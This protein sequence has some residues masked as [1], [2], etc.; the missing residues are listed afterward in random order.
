MHLQI[1]WEHI[2][3]TTYYI[4]IHTTAKLWNHTA[5]SLFPHRHTSNTNSLPN[6]SFDRQ[7]VW[8]SRLRDAGRKEIFAEFNAEICVRAWSLDQVDAAAG[9]WTSWDWWS[10][11]KE[12]TVMRMRRRSR[13]RPYY[14]P[15]MDTQHDDVYWWVDVYSR[16]YSQRGLTQ[17][18]PVALKMWVSVWVFWK[19]LSMRTQSVFFL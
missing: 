13:R 16:Y 3:C 14:A 4:G 19:Y 6:V 18:Q 5:F 2:V 15:T 7:Q 10:G 12:G 9:L 11:E 17:I 8:R 1:L